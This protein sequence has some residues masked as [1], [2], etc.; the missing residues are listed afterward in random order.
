MYCKR[1]MTMA[2]C[3]ALW[4]IP[5]LLHG[6]TLNKTEQQFM[7]MAAE[8]NMT[9]AH[10]G[11]M[12]EAQASGQSVKDFGQ[13]LSKDHTTAYE[14]LSVLANKTGTTI[15]KAIGRDRTIESLAHLK[16]TSFDRAFVR[17]EVQSHRMVVAQFKREAEH[18]ENP[19]VK[20]W[21]QNMIPTIEGHLQM[22]ENLAKQEKSAK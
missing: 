2:G 12:A 13:T 7:R 17:D 9:E 1:T 4:S 14:G 10:L 16:G 19:E 20:A 5:A 6:A 22:A 21:A 8:T 15:P 18:G 11:Q 3:A